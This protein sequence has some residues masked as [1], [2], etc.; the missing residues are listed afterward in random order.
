MKIIDRLKT[1]IGS[2]S[3][4]KE[5]LAN[6]RRELVFVSINRIRVF[7]P[8][9]VILY[10]ILTVLDLTYRI[11][12]VW[13]TAGYL[14][15]LYIHIAILV[16]TVPYA[17]FL[18]LIPLRASSAIR[19]WHRLLVLVF[20]AAMFLTGVATSLA[21]QY[22][23]K[24]ITVFIV[25]VF[26]LGSVIIMRT[27]E[28]IVLYGA[29]LALFITGIV[30][31]QPDLDT[32]L[33][34]SINSTVMTVLAWMLSRIIYFTFRKNFSQTLTINK[35]ADSIRRMN[36]ELVASNEEYE[37]SNEELIASFK[38]LMEKEAAL[39]R[40]EERYRLLAENSDDV[41][42]TLGPDLQFTY[43]SPSSLKLRGVPVEEAMKEKLEEIMTPESLNRVL[44]EYSRVLG[45]IEKGG[46]PTVRIEIEQYRKDRS[47]VWVD[48]SIKVMRD[49][50]GR[51]IGYLGV[52]R[53]ITDRKNA[54]MALKKREEQY[55]LLAENSDDVIWTTDTSLTFTYISPSNM[56]LRGYTPEESMSQALDQV[57]TPE[58]IK[59][60]FAEYLRMQPAIERGE[61]VASIVEVEEYRR[62]G[63]TVWVEI[64]I[65]TIQD[66]TGRLL[67]FLGVSRD[68]T[69][70]KKAMDAVRRSEE[71]YRLI[72]ENSEDLIW[73]TDTALAFTYVSPSVNRLI[74]LTVE[75][76]LSKK[77]NELITPESFEEVMAAYASVLPETEAGKN[78]ITH[79]EMEMYRRDCSTIW[80]ET[81]IQNMRDN[82]GNLIGYLGVSRDI[83]ERKKAEKALQ[84]SE[85]TFRQIV[86]SASDYIYRVDFK[87]YYTF[88]NPAAERELGISLKDGEKRRYWDIIDADHRQAAKAF[89][90]D[91]AMRKLPQTYYEFPINRKDGGL[92]WLGVL[93]KSVEIPGAGT[94]FLCLSRDI[95]ERK[96]AEEML[97]EAKEAAEAANR[98]KSEFLANMS[99]E[100]RTPMNAIIGMSHLAMKTNLDPRQ[101]DYLV[102]IDRAAHNLLQ[103]INDI[104]DF[105]KI[106]AG[107][108]DM[109][110]VPFHL[111]EVMA[112]LSTVVSVKAQE[113]GLELIFD[114]QAEIPNRLVGDP[115]RLTQVLVNLC[116][117]AVKFTEKGEIAVRLR[118]LE[119]KDES[120]KIEFTVS[121]TGIGMTDE[122]IAKLFRSFSQA[123]SSTTRKYGGT[124]LGLSI[125]ERLVEMMGGAIAVESRYGS[126]SL[127]RFSAV[128]ALQKGSEPSLTERIGTM[129]G[130]KVLIVDDNQSSRQILMEL[131]ERL[132]FIVSVCASG[133][134]AISELEQSSADGREYDLVLMDW[135]M[136]GMNGLEASRRIRADAGLSK[137]PKII[138]VTAYG[139]E[140]LMNRAEESGIDGF[141]LKPVSP[142]TMLD[143]FMRIFYGADGAGGPAGRPAGSEDPA[144]AVSGI[145]GARILLA[146]DNDLNQQVAIELLEGAGFSVTLAVD[147]QDALEKM[148]PDFHAVLMDVQMPIM[149]GY[150][151]TRHIRS[152]PA[153]DGI[154]IIA[155]TA[156]AMEQ[157]LEMAREAGMVSHVAKPVDP[158]KL[159][160]T[161]AEFI[162][163]DP[164]K[165]FDEKKEEP[166]ADRLRSDRSALP[167]EL[168]GID[169]ADGLSHLAGNVPAYVRL[170]RQFP[171]RQG[172]CVEM[173]RKSLAGN[174]RAEAIRLAHS[175]KS[176]SG[177][178][179]AK[180]LSAASR[181]VEFALKEMRD[182]A[183]PLA[184]MELALAKVVSGLGSWT[185][186]PEGGGRAA[187]AKL[188]QERVRERLK[189]LEKLLKDDD[190]AAIDV[191][192]ELS[193]AGTPSINGFLADIRRH[194]ENY[195]FES[196]LAGLAELVRRLEDEGRPSR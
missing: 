90:L 108:L 117:N 98:M 71:Q 16:F 47:T 83:S 72:A 99:H 140:E 180:D 23:H 137:V 42:F 9:I 172:A 93:T 141:L 158:E 91:M 33:T 51:L 54:E 175:L 79:I 68:I 174:D 46:N 136:P 49:E 32:L 52:S 62:D 143:T 114:T 69:E 100:I 43:I 125:S 134:E 96:K 122:Q 35:Q 170:L 75:E 145:R 48:I 127:F 95:T 44:A 154:P 3:L 159:Y 13:L 10:S 2:D 183:E 34:H 81:T 124:G 181:E 22:N 150:E 18:Y 94:E 31:L 166:A 189:A 188:S 87:G 5:A 26:A 1:I 123:D 56:K 102:K 194:A 64:S 53:D 97:K 173:I 135:K 65:R 24:Q 111:D 178:L 184:V 138:M 168:P 118:L 11:D 169:I 112:N 147:G 185:S 162:K 37:A 58:S 25:I 192:E 17:V 149:D 63:T 106:E 92:M 4:E 116:G 66:D 76:A 40:S 195:D 196:A 177:N 190:T 27:I 38:D 12:G 57:M 21:D 84:E 50:G 45:E 155:M 70:R 153:F 41:I 133:E 67:G 89:Y 148:R 86:E 19:S 20:L 109:E 60:L 126:G 74:G 182:A 103:I 59:K 39:S 139:S 8:V 167:G 73:V 151:A 163:P 105:S 176:V 132:E 142:S 121:D 30:I 152:D 160:R 85:E 119:K 82:G 187:G 161:L 110:N 78:P 156:N 7:V 131:M 15:R 104:L 107:K 144:A 120:V 171:E 88:L 113:K 29:S 193:D 129:R 115:L 130:M 80:I 36:D 61:N 128:F 6:F 77:V 55:R 101:R 157:D 146:E 14:W 191:I 28:S 179:G 186:A 164:S 165:P